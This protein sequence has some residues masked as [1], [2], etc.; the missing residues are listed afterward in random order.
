MAYDP[1]TF[2]VDT[3]YYWQVY[4]IDER[5][6]RTPGPIWTFRTEA[7]SATPDVETM[8]LIPAG[9]FRMGCNPDERPPAGCIPKHQDTPQHTV[10][11]DTYE[12]D[13]YE[14]TNLQYR[15]CVDAHVCN[16]PRRTNSH[17]RSSYYGNP[18]YDYYPVLYVSWWDAQTYCGWQDKR[19]PTEAEWEKAARGPIDT[20]SW[21]WGEE[22]P[23]CT[24]LN[25]TDNTTESWTVCAGDTNKVGSYPA[26]ASPYGVMD[27][28]GNAFEWVYDLFDGVYD[29]RYYR[30]SPYAN[31]TGPDRGREPHQKPYFVLRGGSYR[32]NWYY[33]RTFHRHFGHHGDRVYHDHPYFRNDQV[34]FRCARSVNE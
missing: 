24:R 8:I 32:P 19:L 9:E 6:G 20:R 27:M 14:V 28:A 7:V 15:T 33:P 2:S 16:P 21:P 5:G 12:I 22:S 4:T 1:F 17:K 23:N 29:L 26:G 10:Y 31:P 13:K 18:T 34:G 25:Y 30:T 3:Q 11:L